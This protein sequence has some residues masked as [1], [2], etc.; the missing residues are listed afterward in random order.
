MK[1]S[2]CLYHGITGRFS[3][4]ILRP[5]ALNLLWSQLIVA[6][7]ESAGSLNS[8]LEYYIN[9]DEPVTDTDPCLTICN[10]YL[11]DWIMEYIENPIGKCWA[12]GLC[13]IQRHCHE[14]HG[15]YSLISPRIRNECNLE[16]VAIFWREG[17]ENK[18]KF[19]IFHLDWEGREREREK[20]VTCA[21]TCS[22]IRND[23]IAPCCMC[24]ETRH[25]MSLKRIALTIEWAT[26][27]PSWSIFWYWSSYLRPLPPPLPA[28]LFWFISHKYWE[29]DS[30]AVTLSPCWWRAA[31]VKKD[32]AGHLFRERLGV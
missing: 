17:R 16:T 29:G 2:W 26:L 8:N 25:L 31:I 13:V 32:V 23:E 20:R 1:S 4:N 15:L 3:N 22:L 5:P 6:N 30:E 24:R 19:L 27:I 14:S 21:L 9:Y 10:E 11:A 18:D 28:R 7:K 12:I